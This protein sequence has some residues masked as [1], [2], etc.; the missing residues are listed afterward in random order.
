MN[1]RIKLISGKEVWINT[2]YCPNAPTVLVISCG[3]IESKQQAPY[4]DNWDDDGLLALRDAINCKLSTGSYAALSDT[5]PSIYVGKKLRHGLHD[6]V[7]I[8]RA[9]P[10]SKFVCCIGDSSGEIFP[11]V[12]R[13]NLFA[14]TLP[15]ARQSSSEAMNKR[16]LP[17]HVAA[18]CERLRQVRENGRK[19]DACWISRV[20]DPLW[21]GQPRVASRD[22]DLELLAYYLVDETERVLNREQNPFT[23]KEG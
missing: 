15:T 6:I 1:E 3:R 12:P 7:T 22:S 5:S 13:E 19:Q 21:T 20:Y 17:P 18:A 16:Q 14:L 10:E 9:H 23:S 8:L 11:S 4:W 2:G